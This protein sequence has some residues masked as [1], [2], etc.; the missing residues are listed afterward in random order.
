MNGCALR[1]DCNYRQGRIF[2]EKRQRAPIRSAQP[3]EA[4]RPKATQ[5]G[6]AEK[7]ADPIDTVAEGQMDGTPYL[8]H[9][10][11][12]DLLKLDRVSLWRVEGRGL[13]P[14]RLRLT[15]GKVVWRKSEIAAF[16][17]NPEGWRKANARS[18]R[19]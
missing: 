6:L 17:R 5:G 19:K 9:A 16:M 13:F 11:V 14:A 2:S 1:T 10:E 12:L 8:N 4:G 3:A 18:A 15:P 7:Q